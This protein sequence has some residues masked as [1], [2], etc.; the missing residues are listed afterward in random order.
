M[1]HCLYNSNPQ[2][3]SV[4]SL[5]NSAYVLIAMFNTITTSVYHNKLSKKKRI[6]RC[7]KIAG[8]L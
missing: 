8:L 3:L 4:Q 2:I 7:G 5:V 6:D 1:Y